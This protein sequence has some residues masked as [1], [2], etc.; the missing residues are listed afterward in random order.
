MALSYGSAP[1]Q[2]NSLKQVWLLTS[3]GTATSATIPSAT[4]L[5]NGK[6]GALLGALNNAYADLA[7]AR[8]VF[9]AGSIRIWIRPQTGNWTSS[10]TVALGAGNKPDIT[11]TLAAAPASGSTAYLDIEFVHSVVK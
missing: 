5:A 4:L 3:D 9:G 8:A 7:S 6:G 10:A 1:V 2:T 11:V